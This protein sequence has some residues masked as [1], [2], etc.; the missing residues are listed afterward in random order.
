MRFYAFVRDPGQFLYGESYKSDMESF[1]P[2][3]RRSIVSILG[4]IRP[5]RISSIV[6][7]GSPVMAATWRTVNFLL[8]MISSSKIFMY[9]ILSVHLSQ[10][11]R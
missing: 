7:F 10:Y 3:A 8:Y 5:D 6:D 1:N 11:Y 2:A 9:I 4:L